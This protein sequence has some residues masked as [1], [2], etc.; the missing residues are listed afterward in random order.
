MTLELIFKESKR[1][2]GYLG[3]WLISSWGRERQG[4]FWNISLCHKINWWKT[5][6]DTSQLE[7]G[8]TSQILAK[9]SIKTNNN[10]NGL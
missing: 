6:G 4:E 5:D 8:S 10:R 9:L 7:G 3:K 1:N 2:R